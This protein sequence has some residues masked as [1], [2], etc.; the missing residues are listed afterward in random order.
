MITTVMLIK[1]L[2]LVGL[3]EIEESGMYI[4]FYF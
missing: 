3:P 1:A 2:S 4:L